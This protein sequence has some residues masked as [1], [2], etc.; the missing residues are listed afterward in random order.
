MMIHFVFLKLRKLCNFNMLSKKR[1][2]S[3]LKKAHFFY[4]IFL[5]ITVSLSTFLTLLQN[6]NRKFFQGHP[7]GYLIVNTNLVLTQYY[8]IAYYSFELFLQAKRLSSP[9]AIK[10]Q[11]NS[12]QVHTDV[13][14]LGKFILNMFG[15]L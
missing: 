9:A 8:Y 3:I 7:H 5:P 6:Y 15:H 14:L 4:C 11:R 10:R 2:F 12:D 1:R 13:G